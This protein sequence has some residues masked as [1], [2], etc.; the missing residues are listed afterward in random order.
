[1]LACTEA[2]GCV[3]SQALSYSPPRVRCSALLHQ[4]PQN[5]CIRVTA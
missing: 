2:P 1:M 5:A 3:C 4:V